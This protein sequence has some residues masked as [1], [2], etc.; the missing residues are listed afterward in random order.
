[1]AAGPGADESVKEFLDPDHNQKLNL[2]LELVKMS[3]I[4]GHLHH[5]HSDSVF[6]Q[7]LKTCPIICYIKGKHIKFT[8]HSTN[9]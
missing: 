4:N 1:M 3:P 5:I 7:M 6:E 8:F 2:N 9:F